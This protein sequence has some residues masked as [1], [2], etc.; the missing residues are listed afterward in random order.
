LAQ[1]FHVAPTTV[2]V[3][4]ALAAVGVVALTFLGELLR[5]FYQLVPRCIAFQV[6]GHTQIIRNN[7]PER[8]QGYL[9]RL[10]EPVRALGQLQQ[11]AAHIQEFFGHPNVHGN[12]DRQDGI[13]P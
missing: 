6:H 12:V 1:P 13:D 7:D 9:A 5:G 11:G 10:D 2:W 8:R 4:G 3:F